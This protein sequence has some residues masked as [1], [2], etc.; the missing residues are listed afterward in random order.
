MSVAA[1]KLRENEVRRY[2]TDQQPGVDVQK[3][4]KKGFTK[5]EKVLWF[6]GLVTIFS[7]CLAIVSNQASIYNE[8]RQISQTQTKVDQTNETNSGLKTQVSE[9]SAP[10]RIKQ[11]AEQKLGMTLNVDS[12]KVVK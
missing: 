8:T 5:G 4:P 6:L 10:E 2:R 9:L 3:L 11:Y 1:Q 12:V 7:L